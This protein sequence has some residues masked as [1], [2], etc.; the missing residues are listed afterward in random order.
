MKSDA[1][2]K[3]D[4]TEELTWEPTVTSRDITVTADAGVVTLGGTVPLYAERKS[5]ERAVQRV[6]G[7]KAIALEIEVHLASAH[8][9]NDVE[10][11]RAVVDALRWHVWVPSHVQATV[12]NGW[13]TLTGTVER[14][15]E[16]SSAEDSVNYLTGVTGVSNNITLKPSVE[17]SVQPTAVKAAIEKALIRNAEVDA[18]NIKVTAAGTK[19]TLVGTVASWDER[20]EA[21]SAA[22]N[23]PG[24]TAVVNELA[25]AF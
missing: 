10:V 23:A 11:A 25:V 20:M 1:Q 13:V 7:V 8:E 4:V 6:E 5:A 24:V 18:E 9:K 15:Y 2:L 3:M 12:E 22:W 21:G 17:P 14:E 16:R 19:V